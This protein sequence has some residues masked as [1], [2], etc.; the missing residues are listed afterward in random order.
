[1]RVVKRMAGARHYRT[2]LVLSG[3]LVL[4]NAVQA[5]TA[6]Q[7]LRDAVNQAWER[8]PQIQILEARQAEVAAQETAATSL[9]PAAPSLEASGRSDRLQ[10][11]EGQNELEIGLSMPLWLPGQRAAHQAQVAATQTNL[12]GDAQALR[13]RLAGEVREAIWAVALA[14]GEE[15]L[16]K[17]RVQTAKVLEQDVARRTHAG[18]LAHTDLNLAQNENLAAQSTLLEAQNRLSQARQAYAIL[19]GSMDLP[20]EHEE[21]V[22]QLSTL[23]THPQLEAARSGIEIA[24]AQLRVTNAS[25]RDAPELS[26][27]TRHERGSNTQPYEDSLMLALRLPLATQARNQPLVAAAQTALAQAQS[28]Y[29]QLRRTLELQIKQAEYAYEA[30]QATVALAGQQQEIM[31]D[32]LTLSQRAF[33]LGEL[34]LLNF[35]QIKATVFGAEQNYLQQKTALGRSKARLNQAQGI[36]P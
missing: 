23:E 36:L 6:P 2:A 25:R 13:L 32:N 19:V 18:E 24:Q 26:I 27:G 9:L 11:N 5:E 3:A 16:A 4:V 20:V 22:Q 30:A 29:D 31:R 8:N 35:L 33:N 12:T 7:T 34:G 28:D 15:A 17:Q 10:E 1:M 21:A 14:Q